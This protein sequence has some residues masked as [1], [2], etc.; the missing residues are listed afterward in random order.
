M[1]ML[2]HVFKKLVILV[3]ML[4]LNMKN[5]VLV[6]FSATFI[7]VNAPFPPIV[8]IFI[9]LFMHCSCSDS[10][11]KG[12]VFFLFYE[13]SSHFHVVFLLLMLSCDLCSHPIVGTFI[14]LFS[15]CFCCLCYFHSSCYCHV[16]HLFHLSYPF[17]V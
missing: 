6:T 17:L 8:N 13:L 12:L 5:Q 16:D 1:S 4:T 11:R 15:L 14:L 3:Q 7:D 9:L 10:P 2:R